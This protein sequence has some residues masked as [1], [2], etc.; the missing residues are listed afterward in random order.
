[1]LGRSV[2]PKIIYVRPAGGPENLQI[3]EKILTQIIWRDPLDPHPNRPPRNF[4]PKIIYGTF[5]A[6]NF[7]LVEEESWTPAA[8][9]HDQPPAR[10]LVVLCE[11]ALGGEAF[12]R[13][14]SVDPHLFDQPWGPKAR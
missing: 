1:M 3:V 5:S 7:C 6:L 13:I 8:G 10:G 14:V 11:L 12:D 4:C 2:V 9:A